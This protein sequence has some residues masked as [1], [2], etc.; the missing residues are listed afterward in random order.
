MKKIILIFFTSSFLLS[1]STNSSNDNSNNPS[2]SDLL[3][4]TIKTVST[5]STFNYN[6]NKIISIN[7][8]GTN[9]TFSYTGDFISSSI[10]SNSSST[11]TIT[12]SYLNNLLN[13]VTGPNNYITFT[14]SN[15]VVTENE[16]IGSFKGTYIR[17]YSQGNCVKEESYYTSN[18]VTTLNG[19]ATYTYD[20]K[21]SPYKNITGWF[22]LKN[23]QHSGNCDGVNNPVT[24]IFKD[25]SGVTTSSEQITYQY[26]SQDYPISIS[27]S[28]LLVPSSPVQTTT[29][30]YY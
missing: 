17:Y 19:T 8:G 21:N 20:N 7:T 15:G 2:S 23:P 28:D 5:T 4:K 10:Y 11:S 25:A 12:Y 26:N 27:Y 24:Y 13:T 29:I 9:R 22:A 6:G 30:T 1:C 18:G 16:T 3:P 14:Y